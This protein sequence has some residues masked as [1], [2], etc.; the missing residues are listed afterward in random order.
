[1]TER[2]FEND[3][4]ICLGAARSDLPML[5]MSPPLAMD[6]PIAITSLPLKRTIVS[7]G[8]E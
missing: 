6:T 5:M 1:M 2:H 4:R 7:A 8:S 3:L